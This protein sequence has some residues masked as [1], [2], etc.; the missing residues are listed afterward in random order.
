VR[1]IALVLLAVLGVTLGRASTGVAQGAAPAPLQGFVAGVARLWANGDADG[2]VGLAPA[3]GR[4]LLDV[5]AGSAGPVQ[6]R[7]A[8]AALRSV[9]SSHSTVSVRAERSTVSGGQPVSGFGELRW[10][11]RAR[12]VTTTDSRA[13]FV[14]VEWDGRAWRVR[15]IR[16]LS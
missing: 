5:G 13:V 11:A 9:F 6:R 10:L 3:D 2:I 15:E 12:G 16:I 7:Q 14:G 8:A 4:M 1:R